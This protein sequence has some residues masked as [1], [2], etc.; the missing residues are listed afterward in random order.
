M[1]VHKLLVLGVFSVFSLS[2]FS[3]DA[4]ACG[5]KKKRGNSGGNCN[6]CSAP[7]QPTCCGGGYASNMPM[8]GV[9]MAMPMPGGSAIVPASGPTTTP[10]GT[11]VPAGGVAP[12][13]T[14]IP[15]SGTYFD[16]ATQSYYS[17]PGAYT[18]QGLIQ[19]ANG[20][21][22]YSNPTGTTTRRGLFRR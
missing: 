5:R 12:G 7:V 15:A 14:V 17:Y 2:L 11:V 9:P 4:D 22:Y 18:N 20:N 21:Y 10:N 16:P 3:A 19:G 1:S 13:S 8:N 6:T